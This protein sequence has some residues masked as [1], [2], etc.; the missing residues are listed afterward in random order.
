MQRQF[1]VTIEAETSE[2]IEEVI[3]NRIY[4]EDKDSPFEYTIDAE[5]AGELVRQI[6]DS[7]ERLRRLLRGRRPKLLKL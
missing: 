5:P 4:T 6:L 1:I 7:N 2:Q 3:A